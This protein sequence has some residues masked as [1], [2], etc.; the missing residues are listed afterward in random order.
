VTTNSHRPSHGVVDIPLARRAVLDSLRLSHRKHTVYGL[1]EMDVTDARLLIDEH[2]VS[3][4]EA[5]SFT[6]YIIACLAKAVDANRYMHGCRN[7]RNQLVLFDQVD[8]C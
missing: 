8:V 5:L 1:I 4:G 6:A 3:T 2:E 7:W